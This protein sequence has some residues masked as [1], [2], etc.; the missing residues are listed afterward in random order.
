MEVY[1]SEFL[2]ST[3]VVSVVVITYN[4][5]DYI[6]E[7]ID[8]II[9]QVVNFPIE[10]ILADDASTDCT[11]DICVSYQKKYPGLIKLI[12]NENNI[13]LIRNY[14]NVLSHC[15]GKYIAQI[16]GDDYWCDVNKLSIQKSYLDCNT[17]VGLVYTDTYRLSNGFFQK[18]FVSKNIKS[19][20]DHLIHAG[21]LAPNTWMYRTEYSPLKFLSDDNAHYVDE[22]YA[23]L[24]DIFKISK[25]SFIPQYMAVYREIKGSLSSYNSFEHYYRFKK[26]IFS[27]KKDY[28][29]KYNVKIEQ[30][31]CD[32]LMNGYI[33]LI[34]EAIILSDTEFINEARNYIDKQKINYK[35]IESLVNKS[36]QYRTQFLNIQKSKAYRLG[37][38]L[39]RPFIKV[40]NYFFYR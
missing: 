7:C 6:S 22:S 25:V 31:S 20:E 37:K 24:L 1:N 26:G 5:Q 21:Y 36:I 8:N 4:H 35:E 28:I 33:D 40:R 16:A 9:N 39:L 27:I 13:G 30:L 29:A 3:P 14:L 19:F 18:D 38:I 10:I 17:E 23:Y 34:E 32:I 12:L 15:R 2:I 11:R